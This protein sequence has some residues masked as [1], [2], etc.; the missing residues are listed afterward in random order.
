MSFTR[1]L[2]KSNNANG[3]VDFSY[4][5]GD[6]PLRRIIAAMASQPVVRKLLLQYT[7]ISATCCTEVFD[8][9]CSGS[10]SSSHLAVS[11][12]DMRGCHLTDE[13]LL[14][15]SKFLSHNT[16]LK[17]LTLQSN[18]FAFRTDAAEAFVTAI[19]TSRLETLSLSSNPD[20][21]DFVSMLLKTIDSKHLMHLE[22]S[23]MALETACEPSLSAFFA[24]PRCHLRALYISG[25]SIDAEAVQKIHDNLHLN[26]TVVTFDC[27]ALYT[28]SDVDL[29]KKLLQ[30]KQSV[31][32]RNQVLQT[33]IKKESLALLR[34]S[35]AALLPVS[36]SPQPPSQLSRSLPIEII[37]HI[38][39]F[40]A[41][42][43][44]PAQRIRIFDFASSR[45]TLPPLLPRLL[46]RT[47]LPDPSAHSSA[48][49]GYPDDGCTG[50]AQHVSC[51]REAEHTEWLREIQCDAF[52]S[53]S[54]SSTLVIPAE[55]PPP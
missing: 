18:C 14:A 8:Y 17:T 23:S 40:Y 55:A 49:T 48:N 27:Y 19:N 21:N 50:S 1:R 36:S 6:S 20:K 52:D 28:V 15:I 26:Y 39:S 10:L 37:L 51:R 31:L 53:H 12:I 41:P 29:H 45:T 46:Q 47:C 4:D 25:N 30:D 44:S 2:R 16:T 3:V 42:T 13:G 5:K 35:R 33:I 24:S 32:V 11:E 9:L 38:L 7:Y 34:H 22:L 54:S 43:L